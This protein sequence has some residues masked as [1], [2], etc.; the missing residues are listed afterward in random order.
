MNKLKMM[1]VAILA[2][3]LMLGSCIDDKESASVETIRNAKAA[4]LNAIA[5]YKNAMAEAALINAKAEALVKEAEAAAT[6]EATAEKKQEFEIKLEQLKAEAALAIAIAN[7]AAQAAQQQMQKE[8]EAHVLSLFNNYQSANSTLAGLNDQLF[9]EQVALISAQADLAD[10]T[11]QKADEILGCNTEIAKQQAIKTALQALPAND[12]AAA[13]A[14][15]EANKN[16][17][18]GITDR[19]AVANSELIKATTAYHNAVQAIAET[20]TAIQGDFLATEYPSCVKVVSVT[21]KDDNNEA[22]SESYDT[23]II[24]D[25]QISA[26]LIKLREASYSYDEQLG[27]TDGSETGTLYANLKAAR[28]A[29]AEAKTA[30][31]APDA[32]AADRLAY[33]TAMEAT[34]AAQKAIDQAKEDKATSLED[35]NKLLAAQTAFTEEGSA[36]Y[37]TAIGAAETAGATEIAARLVMEPIQKEIEAN[38]ALQNALDAV[39]EGLTDISDLISK[40]DVAISAQ[41]KLITIA[42][43]ISNKDQLVAFTQEKIKNLQAEIAE[44]VLIVA[45]L[46]AELDAELAK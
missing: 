3:G 44:Q 42:Q 32:T 43:G 40:C 39:A 37:K 35:Y 30:A 8:A 14:A 12:K 19:L 23:Y 41:Q 38:G 33:A 46:K 45:Y 9:S 2:S 10:W 15:A 1:T 29:E 22:A 5:T 31:S 11:V 26:Q 6:T 34:Q 27:K 36:A 13:V 21:P 7:Q 24:Y 20:E 18:K 28:E 16:A 17:L 4:Q 25:K